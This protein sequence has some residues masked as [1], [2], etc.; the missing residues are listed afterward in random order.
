MGPDLMAEMRAQ[1]ERFGT[2]VMQGNVT[3]VDL[4][5]R[6]FTL[7]FANGKSA[8]DRGAHHRDRRVG[9]LARDRIRSEA[10]GARRVHLRD[11]RR[12]LLQ[13][14]ADRRR[15]RR[16]LRDGRSDL[17]DTLRVQGHRRPPA[18]LAARVEDHAGQGVR[19][20]EDRVH[21]GLGSGRRPRRRQGRGHRH[22][23][24]QPE[25]RSAHEAAARRRVHRDRPHAEHGALH[26]ADRARCQRVHRHALR[27]RRPASG[28][29]RRGRR[30]GSHL[31]AGDHGGRFR[32]HGRDRCRTIRRGLVGSSCVGRCS[33][34]KRRLDSAWAYPSRVSPWCDAD[35]GS[36][37][38]R[39]SSPQCSM[40]SSSKCRRLHKKP[41]G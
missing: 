36:V 31:P 28:R 9:A 22:R 16:R 6:P 24:A 18:R 12:L 38:S 10:V 40:L 32:L 35:A 8:H 17:P 21:L 5:N 26:R 23:R 30:A 7:T 25:D 41:H 11:V 37:V 14:Q 3:K 39:R 27:H 1:A 4:Q 13:R 34:T 33:R 19:E 15:R 29:V 2:E 20:P